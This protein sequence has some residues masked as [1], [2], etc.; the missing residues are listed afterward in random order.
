MANRCF[1]LIQVTLLITGLF[2]LG[3]I[4]SLLWL[5]LDIRLGNA[6]RLVTTLLLSSTFF[7]LVSAYVLLATWQLLHSIIIT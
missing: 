6:R 5:I 7:A 4:R 1:R 3:T 2:A